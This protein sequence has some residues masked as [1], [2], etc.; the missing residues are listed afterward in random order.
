MCKYNS[1]ADDDKLLLI[2]LVA[3]LT[4]LAVVIA[5][6]IAIICIRRRCAGRASDVDD[7]T[8]TRSDSTLAQYSVNT[9]TGPYGRTERVWQRSESMTS[10]AWNGN[11][12]ISPQQAHR[13]QMTS[14]A[15]IYGDRYPYPDESSA[16]RG[17][18]YS[19][20]DHVDTLDYF[21]DAVSAYGPQPFRFRSEPSGA[22][23]DGLSTSDIE[24]NDVSS[25]RYPE[26]AE[27]PVVEQSFSRQQSAGTDV[28]SAAS[29]KLPKYYRVQDPEAT[30]RGF[31]ETR[32]ENAVGA[33]RGSPPDGDTRQTGLRRTLPEAD[34]LHPSQL[35]FKRRIS[36][37]GDDSDL[38]ADSVSD[39]FEIQDRTTQYDSGYDEALK[40][41]YTDPKL[42]VNIFKC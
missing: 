29:C 14:S 2:G 32:T 5:T 8:D 42:D 13:R 21:T 18:Y 20:P 3:A 23:R 40:L 7:K 17:R 4:S 22:S 6:A 24:L 12:F 30:Y 31:F 34:V 15:P 26:S 27:R 39:Q 36:T 35:P 1:F 9:M 33:A 19:A 37:N 10:P 25:G 16:I 11:V 38:S 41:Y 28:T